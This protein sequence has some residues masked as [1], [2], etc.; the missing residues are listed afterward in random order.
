MFQE[1]SEEE[2]QSLLKA[3]SQ[4]TVL[5]AGADG[6]IDTAEVEWATKLTTIRSYAYAEELKPYYAAV[7]E[8]FDADVKE[9]IAQLPDSIEERSTILTTRLKELNSILPKLNNQT[10]FRLY[11]SYLSFA[12]HVAKASGGFLRFASISKEEKSLMT[13]P[14]IT[15]IILEIEE[16]ES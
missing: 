6:N 12:E 13:L 1:I 5:I 14:M 4:I 7:G 8:T 10:A 9:L 3:I 15:P 2:Q 11:E 16:E